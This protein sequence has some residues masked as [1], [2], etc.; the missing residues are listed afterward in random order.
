MNKLN[1][2]SQMKDGVLQVAV[3]WVGFEMSERGLDEI[4]SILQQ[5]KLYVGVVGGHWYA[6]L[7][8]FVV[9]VYY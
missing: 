8:A 7:R 1:A 3:V 2:S 4:K 5:G 6:S 9:A